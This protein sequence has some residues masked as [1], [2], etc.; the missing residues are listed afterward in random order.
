M[1]ADQPLA[2]LGVEANHVA[3]AV[4]SEVARVDVD[5]NAATLWSGRWVD[6]VGIHR[7]GASDRQG[8]AAGNAGAGIQGNA[9]R[10]ENIPF[11]LS[12]GTKSR[13][14]ADL[15]KDAV[16]LTAIG[17]NNRRAAGGRQRAANLKKEDRVRVALGVE[18]EC[19][20]QLCRRRKA[21]DS[22]VRVSPPRS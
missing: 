3:R 9:C 19:S 13:R 2:G 15:P 22:D 16:A 18:S 7:H 10:R 4:A 1:R 21:I 6:E 14:A 11:E 20:G 12:G 5:Q 17:K 8:S